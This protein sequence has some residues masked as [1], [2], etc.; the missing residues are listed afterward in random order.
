MLCNME[1]A[2]VETAIMA[3]LTQPPELLSLPHI[4]IENI[5]CLASFSGALAACSCR[6]LTLTL[7]GNLRAAT[8][9]SPPQL[10]WTTFRLWKQWQSTF[11]HRSP[12]CWETLSSQATLRRLLRDS[13]TLSRARYFPSCQ[14]C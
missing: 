9:S 11:M 8:P 5:L 14:H 13:W 2:K 4:A 12:L 7:G 10:C 3:T 1:V 6:A